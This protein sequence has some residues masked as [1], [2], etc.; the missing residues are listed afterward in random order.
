MDQDTCT[1]LMYSLLMS[2][3]DYSNS[4]LVRITDKATTLNA[5][6]TKCCSQ[7]GS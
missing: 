1:I 3:L 7:G 5:M 4:I 2:H 6:C